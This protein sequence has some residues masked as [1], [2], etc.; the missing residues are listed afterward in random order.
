M[1]LEM[2]ATDRKA[3]AK[4]ISEQIHEPV[5][6]N[7]MPTCSYSIGSVTVERNGAIACDDLEA[8]QR[9]M[10]FF[11]EQGWIQE[12][13]DDPA[14]ENDMEETQIPEATGVNLPLNDFTADGLINLVRMFYTRQDM[15]NAMTRSNRLKID[16]EVINLLDEKNMSKDAVLQVIRNETELEMIQGMAISETRLTID[17]DY[18]LERPTDWQHYATLIAALV[19]KAD[20]AH[21][22]SKKR[23]TPAEDEMKYF[24]NSYLNQ[25][26]FGGNEHKELRQVLMG[27]LHGFAAFRSV[28]KMDAH[29]KKYAEMRKALHESEEGEHHEAD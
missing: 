25:L 24:C 6:Y 1:R 23:I 10:P 8:W 9:L 2:N 11:R 21:H 13:D 16:E 19:S 4:S 27:H 29:K 26:G 14:E 18:D 12:L 20:H 28:D 15:I 22:A 7:G 17:F 3:L 5:H